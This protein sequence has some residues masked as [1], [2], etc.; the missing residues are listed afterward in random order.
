MTI[1]I[2][3]AIN[4][5]V[6]FIQKKTIY[7]WWLIYCFI[8]IIFF[9]LLTNTYEWQRMNFD[10]FLF[11]NLRINGIVNW[12]NLNMTFPQG[13]CFWKIWQF[14]NLE[15]LV[16]STL[17]KMMFLP[18]QFCFLRIRT[19]GLTEFKTDLTTI[20]DWQILHLQLLQKEFRSE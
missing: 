2:F 3:D 10:M 18:Q 13:H 7:C 8:V 20:S 4:D 16:I 19:D 14:D 17:L 5:I 9:I 6:H 12:N 15:G 1:W 11:Q